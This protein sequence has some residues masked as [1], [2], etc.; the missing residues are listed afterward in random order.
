MKELEIVERKGWIEDSRRDTKKV[1]Q[2]DLCNEGK[3]KKGDKMST[4]LC[5]II[6]GDANQEYVWRNGAC[7]S[8]SLS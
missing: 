1:H 4:V 8:S 2:I 6:K 5:A 7:V 3:P